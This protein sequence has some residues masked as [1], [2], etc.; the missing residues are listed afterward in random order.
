[1]I[2]TTVRAD[3][4]VPRNEAGPHARVTIRVP[5]SR[6]T[7]PHSRAPSRQ[8]SR[9]AP[10][11]RHVCPALSTAPAANSQAIA[12]TRASSSCFTATPAATPS[13]TCSVDGDG[14]PLSPCCSRRSRSTRSRASRCTSTSSSSTCRRSARSTCRSSSSASPKRSTSMGGVLLHLRDSVLVR[15]KPDDLP[16]GIELDI[17]SLDSTSTRRSTSPTCKI[18]DGVTLRHRRDR[19]RGARPAAARRGRAGCRRGG[20]GRGSRRGRGARGQR[21]RNL[22]ATT[23]ARRS[24]SRN[25]TLEGRRSAPGAADQ[26]LW[27]QRT[28]DSTDRLN[29]SSFADRRGQPDWGP[30]PTSTSEPTPTTQPTPALDGH[31]RR[32]FSRPRRADARGFARLEPRWT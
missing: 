14:K 7:L 19:G 9:Q 16:S 25:R 30:S 29:R 4:R 17:T 11:R 18:P 5:M 12:W 27:R 1:M 32:A 13:S 10:P 8:R 2:A 6:P 15:A 26:R 28:I 31:G 20:R 24:P 21:P 3:R 23:A 22:Q